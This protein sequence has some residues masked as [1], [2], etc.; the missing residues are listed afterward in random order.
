[1][2]GVELPNAKIASGFIQAHQIASQVIKAEGNNKFLGVGGTPHIGVQKYFHQT[3]DGLVRK[4]SKIF[5]A[6]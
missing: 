3:D 4:D 1:L 5:P 2:G 6:P